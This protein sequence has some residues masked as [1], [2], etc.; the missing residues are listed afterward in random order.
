MKYG[1]CVSS[2]KT[3]IKISQCRCN[4]KS[5]QSMLEHKYDIK[6][7]IILKVVFA[8]WLIINYS[9][10]KFLLFLMFSQIFSR[11][12]QSKNDAENNKNPV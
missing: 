6:T 8:V 3:K 7:N 9:A 2:T 4:L 5:L 11:H 1:Q 10:I 12:I